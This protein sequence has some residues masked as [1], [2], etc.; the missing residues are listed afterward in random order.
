[1]SPSFVI[2]SIVLFWHRTLFACASNNTVLVTGVVFSVFSVFLGS[3][4]HLED[5]DCP[6]AVWPVIRDDQ[7]SAQLRRS[8][9]VDSKY[10]PTS[11]HIQPHRMWD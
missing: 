10:S 4:E 8:P 6:A 9:A 7:L 11:N 2:F 5:F 3:D 1:M